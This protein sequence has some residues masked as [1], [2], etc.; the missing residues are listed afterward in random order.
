VLYVAEADELD[1]YT[2]PALRRT[3]V[4]R[5]LPD[6]DGLDRLKGLAIGSDHTVYV[7][8]GSDSVLG[9]PRG[10]VLA[11]RPDGRTTVAVGGVHDAEGLAVDPG[12][13]LWLAANSA[14]SAP[15][16]LV[17]LGAGGRR[18]VRLLA[19]HTAPL[20][21]GFVTG[22]PLAPPWRRGAVLAAH[23][24][25]DPALPSEPAV[26]WLPWTGA[27]L[28]RPTTL[29]GGFEQDGV[30]WGRPTDAVAGGDG[31]LYVVDDTAGAVY[32][33]APPR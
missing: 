20:G 17:T 22:S 31:A 29:A 12:G 8:V 24:A 4:A 26:L 6:P 16:A 13:H 32:R 5:G 18:V 3:V 28:G 11:I 10:V 2:W 14:G 23:G 21:L 19:P 27:T 33:L 25:H 1:R 9:G 30:R 7:G 15:D